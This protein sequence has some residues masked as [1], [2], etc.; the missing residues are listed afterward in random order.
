MVPVSTGRFNF[1]KFHMQPNKLY[2]CAFYGSQKKS[3]HSLYSTILSIFITETECVYCA[4]QTE[5][6]IKVSVSD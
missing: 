2:L 6:L 1:K 4:L 5:C 3:H